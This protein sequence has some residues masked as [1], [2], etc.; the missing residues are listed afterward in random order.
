MK[1]KNITLTENEIDMNLKG[2]VGW[3]REGKMIKKDFCFFRF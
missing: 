1:D 3:R 2:I